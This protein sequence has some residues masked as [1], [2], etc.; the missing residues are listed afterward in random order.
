MAKTSKNQSKKQNITQKN[1]K[2]KGNKN[3][4]KYKSCKSKIYKSLY[5]GRYTT[6]M[7]I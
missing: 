1:R 2:Y 5:G 3:D 7:F 6:N 4:Y